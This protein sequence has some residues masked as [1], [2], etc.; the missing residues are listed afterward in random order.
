VFQKPDSGQG[1]TIVEVSRSH[2][3]RYTPGRTSL[4]AW[5]VRH[6]AATC[7]TQNKHNRQHPFHERYSNPRSQQLRGRRPTPQKTDPPT[8]TI[9]PSYFVRFSSKYSAFGKSLC[10]FKRCWEWCSRA[11]IQ[12]ESV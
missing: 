5:S 12:P 11:S 9:F 8:S 7:T 3:I 2:K 10:T 6:K 1:H 4:N